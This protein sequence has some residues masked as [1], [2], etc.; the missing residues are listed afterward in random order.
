VAGKVP[1]GKK[2]RTRLR[3]KG[4]APLALKLTYTE[5]GQL[6]LTVEKR[7]ALLQRRR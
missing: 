3:N 1:L 7:L 4:R 6:P 5:E 2:V